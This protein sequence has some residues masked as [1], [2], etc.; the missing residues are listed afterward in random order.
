MLRRYRNRKHQ[1]FADEMRA[2]GYSV[3]CVHLRNGYKGPAVWFPSEPKHGE[4]PTTTKWRTHE[5]CKG[6]AYYA[7]PF[8]IGPITITVTQKVIRILTHVALLCYL[9]INRFP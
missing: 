5:I 4:L 8:D 2:A 6:L 9:D 1:Q 3:A 7:Y